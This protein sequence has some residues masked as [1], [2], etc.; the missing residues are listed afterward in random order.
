MSKM[1][2]SNSR[3]RVSKS[4]QLTWEF[5][6]NSVSQL[7]FES[8]FFHFKM[9][10]LVG[11]K[12]EFYPLSISCWKPMISSKEWR[13]C[14]CLKGGR[15]QLK[16]AP[17]NSFLFFFFIKNR[18][19]TKRI[20]YYLRLI[21]NFYIKCPKHVKKQYTLNKYFNIRYRIYTITT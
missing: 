5:V 13:N 16:L 2:L 6:L 21:I 19:K 9:S 15:S 14:P 17:K 7:I 12:I 3:S 20:K 18:C 10:S 8:I 11:M 1:Y 4:T